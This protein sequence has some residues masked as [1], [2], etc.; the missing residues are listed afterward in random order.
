MGW[1]D[2]FLHNNG[3]I[4]EDAKEADV[5][6]QEA[7]KKYFDSVP[8]K[9]KIV[10]AVVIDVVRLKQLLR[11]ELIDLEDDEAEEAEVMLDLASLSHDYRIKSAHRLTRTL[12]YAERKYEYIYSLVQQIY[13]VIKREF[14]LA[15]S[16][17]RA[18]S[19]S[20]KYVI[21]LQQQVEL[22]ILIIKKINELNEKHGPNRFHELFIDLAKGEHI[23]KSLS[24]RERRLL[25]KMS[26]RSARIDE[27]LL[28]KWGARVVQELEERVHEAEAQGLIGY[29]PDM[30]FE[31]VNQSMFEDFVKEVILSIRQ[32]NAKGNKKKG[33]PSDAMINSFIHDF[34][35]W[36]NSM[37]LKEE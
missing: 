3:K 31:F 27:S 32:E 33:L 9:E 12:D 18:G 5:K 21:H 6:I 17:Q 28:N 34:R 4:G 11:T 25:Q 14:H 19:N 23:I 24:E 10:H 1:L 26:E 22:E 2:R 15:S 37:G 35:Q 7:W 20:P 13:S 36:F 30:E 29:N 8:E 16:L